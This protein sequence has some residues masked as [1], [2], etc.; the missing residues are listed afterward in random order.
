V[1]VH[2]NINNKSRDHEFEREQGKE[3]YMDGLEE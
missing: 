2:N 1:C 3:G